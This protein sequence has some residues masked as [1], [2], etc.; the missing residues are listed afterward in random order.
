VTICDHCTRVKVGGS[1]QPADSRILGI[2][3]GVQ[4]GS[5]GKKRGEERRQ[6]CDVIW[7]MVF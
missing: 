6:M 7:M 2:L 3:F 4:D 1:Q 5:V